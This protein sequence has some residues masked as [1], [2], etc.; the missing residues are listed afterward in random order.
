MDVAPAGTSNGS[1]TT[2]ILFFSMR[3][4]MSV[5]SSTASTVQ[6]EAPSI[7]VAHGTTMLFRS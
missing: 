7:F 2:L 4:L 5:S 3:K 6:H 1:V